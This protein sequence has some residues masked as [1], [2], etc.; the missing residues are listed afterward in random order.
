[1]YGLEKNIGSHHFGFCEAATTRQGSL[2]ARG[3]KFWGPVDRTAFRAV[4]DLNKRR[5]PGTDMVLFHRPI[6]LSLLGHSIHCYFGPDILAQGVSEVHEDGNRLA[7]RTQNLIR[8]INSS[9]ANTASR[10][11]TSSRLERM[12]RW[13]RILTN[14]VVRFRGSRS[15]QRAVKF[16]SDAVR[17]GNPSMFRKQ[18]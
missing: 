15:A 11:S 17:I 10:S 2:R 1:M 4:H 18:K 12:A 9:L 8:S 5:C 14:T 3:G 16:G 6:S 7:T 13:S